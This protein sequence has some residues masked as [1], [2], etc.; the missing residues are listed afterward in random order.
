MRNI[1]ELLSRELVINTLVALFISIPVGWIALKNWSNNFAY[2][3]NISWWIFGLSGIAIF[4][5]TWLTVG[6]FTI[7]A[8]RKNPVEA[9]RYE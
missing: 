8:A 6:Y 3:T 1:L 2:K 9:L 4:I 5:L 7:R